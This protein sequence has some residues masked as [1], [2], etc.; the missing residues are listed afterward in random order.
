[1]KGNKN[2][3]H[4]HNSQPVNGG[5]EQA[6]SNFWTSAKPLM[7]TG[8][9]DFNLHFQNLSKDLKAQLQDKYQGRELCKGHQ[10]GQISQL[11]GSGKQQLTGQKREVKISMPKIFDSWVSPE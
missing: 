2:Q 5:E 3:E 6:S 11:K 10:Q 7:K 1:M 4:L 8:I 9:C